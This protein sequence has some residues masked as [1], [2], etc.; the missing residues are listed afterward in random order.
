MSAPISP[1]GLT[2]PSDTTSVKTATSSAPAAC[3]F[4][5]IGFR[6]RSWPNK[7]GVLHHDAGG[8]VVD[9]RSRI[10]RRR[11]A[12]GG[13]A[14][15]RRRS[16]MPRHRLDR[17]A[18]VR[19]QAAGEHRLLPLGDAVRH[20]HRLGGRGRAVIHRGVG[21][22]HAGQQRD[23]GLELEQILQRALRD[24]G[25]IR[26]VGGEEF[27][28]LDQVI[29]A[30][31]HVVLVG[32]GSRRRTA[33]TPAA[34]FLRRHAAEHALDLDLGL[35]AA[36]GRAAPSAACR[37]ACR[38]TARR[39]RRRRSAP[40]FRAVFRRKRQIAHSSAPGLLSANDIDALDDDLA[41]HR[42]R[43]V[44]FLVREVMQLVELLRRRAL[45]A[46]EGDRGRERHLRNPHPSALVL[47]HHADRLVRIGCRPRSPASPP[48][49]GTSACGSSTAPPRTP[50]RDRPPRRP[51][52]AAAR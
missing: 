49:R 29:D 34:T 40:A 24:L 32:A 31:R 30:R 47:G 3:A 43:D 42:V 9:R 38:R 16:A 7:S 14:H 36:A 13:S 37:P 27:R 26:R 48:R 19:M 50:P 12:S 45:L 20:Q 23:L 46:R 6:S 44:A 4:S 18:I 28:A 17:L 15:D 10:P 11:A 33:P 22:L 52:R 8:L 39:C 35:G 2:R 51:N 25:L 41:L 1:G 21:D 5:A